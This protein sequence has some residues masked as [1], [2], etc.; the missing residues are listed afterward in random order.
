MTWKRIFHLF[1]LLVL[2]TG[3]CSA[4][5]ATCSG[6]TSLDEFRLVVEPPKGSQ[7]I[8]LSKINGLHSGEKLKYTPVDMD[9]DIKGKAEIGL[10]LV[11]VPG[12]SPAEPAVLEAR[13]AAKP[14]EWSLP[15]DVSIVG[16]VFGPQGL[17][18][19]KVHSLLDKKHQLITQLADY[20]EHN[21]QVGAL[22]DTLSAWEKSPSNQGS[23]N[24]VLSGFSSRYGVSLPKLNAEG[25]PDE[26]AM[27]LLRSVLP[28]LSSYDPLTVE[29]AARMQQSAGLAATMASLFLG[30]PVTLAAGGTALFQNL[31]TVMF[32]DTDFRSAIAHFKPDDQMSLCAKPQPAKSHTRTA[33]LWALRLP[34]SGPPALSLPADLC[35]P[36]GWKSSVKFTLKDA[37]QQRLVPRVQSWQLVSKDGK[38][39]RPI[40]VNAAVENPETLQLDLTKASLSPGEYQLAGKWDWTGFSASGTIRL[41]G[42]DSMGGARLT[43]LSEDRLVEG[44]GSVPIELTGADF[45]FVEKIQ[46]ATSEK[47]DSAVAVLPFTL[48]HNKTDGGNGGLEARVDTKIIPSGSYVLR[49]TQLNGKSFD[50]PLTVHPPN[51]KIQNLPLR[52]NL[53]EPRQTVVLRGSGLDRIDKISGNGAEWQIGPMKPA[54]GPG[55]VEEREAILTLDGSIQKGQHLDICLNVHGLHQPL[56]IP[57]AVEVVGPRPGIVSL[58]RSLPSQIPVELGKDELPAGFPVSFALKTR[59]LTSA[60]VLKLECDSEAAGAPLLTLKP[61]EA[62]ENA[63]LDLAGEGVLFLSLDPGKIGPA[64][65]NLTAI[66]E[67]SVVGA[68]QPFVL[69]HVVRLPQI[70]K[71]ELTD[72]KVDNSLFVG[73][74]TGRELQVIE[75]AGW[76][77]QHGYPVLGIPSV[78]MG[79]PG[80][81][82]LRVSLPWPSPAP[83]APIYIWLRGETTGRATQARY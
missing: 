71:F 19:K 42:F 8:P 29:P 51:P 58:D 44:A 77:A 23:L 16:V 17:D 28:S 27:T 50:L 11:P 46:L 68:S 53:A 65:C 69:G 37:G 21:S 48:P 31:R 78:M 43:L 82:S 67:S 18:I 36:I 57:A 26:Q 35:L 76:D 2:S 40:T 9:S 55:T 83:H 39:I 12:K 59:N 81:Q 32:P 80:K 64:G 38:E 5:L 66:V 61:G 63:K 15:F 75:K 73:V 74:L 4:Q 72:E 70:E 10:I 49:I 60:P 45:E 41:R 24:A 33:Y 22:V 14:A 34:A 6:S 25:K 3:P 47:P 56:S 30:S 13:P 54:A 79:Q 62:S 52:A 1:G 20:A 7:P